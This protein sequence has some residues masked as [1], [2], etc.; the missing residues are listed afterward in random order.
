ML[1]AERG[2]E[3]YSPKQKVCLH[4]TVQYYSEISRIIWVPKAAYTTLPTEKQ[5]LFDV[6]LVPAKYC[7]VINSSLLIWGALNPN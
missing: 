7:R 3:D 2:L 4:E 1:G 5:G 6:N